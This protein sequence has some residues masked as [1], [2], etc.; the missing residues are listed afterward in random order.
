MTLA[1]MSELI[2]GIDL[3]TT[4]SA[5]GVVD[6]GFPILLANEDGRRITR[7]AVWI[8]RNG[9]IEVGEKAL[10]RRSLEPDR[11]VT[12]IKRLMGR[13]ISEAS[14]DFPLAVE[15]G[16][17]GMPRVLGKSPEE[18]SAEILKEMKRVAEWRMGVEIRKA[19]IT[20]PA[21][22]HD[23]QRAA[24]KRAGELAGLEVVRI[25]NEPTA[26]ALAYGLD[27]LG[28]KSRVAVYDLG[29]G[30]FDLSILEMQD[31]VFQ[32]LATHGDTRLG[33]DDLD[34]MIVSRVIARAGL[35]EPSPADRVRLTAEAERVKISLAENESAEFLIPFYDGSRSI[36][37][38]FTRTELE[39]LAAPWIART[40]RHC[41]QALADAALKPEDLNAVVLVG[42]ST[43]MPAVRRAVAEL[44]GSE[45][46]VSQ[47]PDEAIALGATIQG[48]ILAGSLRQVILLDVTPLSL[49]IETFGGLMNVLIPRNTT[50]PCKAGEMFT[51][52]A[53]GQA[54]MRVRVLQ[55]EREMA[56]DN[57]EL[58]VFDVA[59][60]PS[61][62]GQARVGVQFKIDENGLLQ[63]LARDTATGVDTVV[64]IGSAAVDV[65]DA[66]VEAMV[67][68]SV[69][70]A[71]EDMAERV[72]TEA[73]LKAEELLP[74]VESVLA[75]GLALEAERGEIEAAAAAVRAAL[76]TGAANPLKAAVQRLDAATEALAARLV[77]QAMDAA[78]E[79]R[80]AGD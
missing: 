74:A 43:R 18:I 69:E 38:V 13:R 12:S 65:D 42:G 80:M 17:D 54:S 53:D 26:A 79:R 46:D 28:E 48:G 4:N 41:R 51:N 76:A 10:R 33:G 64:E 20:V 66:A 68:E 27:K 16:P 34:A 2:L 50:I 30:T 11:V 61:P 56:R 8:G 55:G 24:T 22:F 5:T 72:F 78:L 1:A 36:G 19:V 63:A 40:L 47:H 39:S 35:P 75:Q 6:S 25:L 21:Y 32:V 15:A 77:E 58:G 3:G 14:D 70:H 31:G 7:S 67:S 73:R 29:G 9:S 44:F 62:K 49:G 57:W 59:F 60:T 45:P 52:A 23:G 37:E 71:F